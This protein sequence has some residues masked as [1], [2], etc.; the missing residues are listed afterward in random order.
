MQSVNLEGLNEHLVDLLLEQCRQ[1]ILINKL[2]DYGICL[3][4]IRIDTWKIVAAIIG[5][6]HDEVDENA[7]R[8]FSNIH[9]FDYMRLE[10]LPAVL[11]YDMLS[12]E[13]LELVETIEEEDTS[14]ISKKVT[15]NEERARER[16]RGHI[17][18]LYRQVENRRYFPETIQEK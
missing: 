13:F 7:L 9:D 11:S 6:A 15:I 18:F 14:I 8:N 16:I 1:D 12:E 2:E 10:N 3:D 5:I 17:Q 4:R